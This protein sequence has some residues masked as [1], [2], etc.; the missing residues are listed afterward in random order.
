MSRKMPSILRTTTGRMRDD[1]DFSLVVT[2]W[3]EKTFGN[4]KSPKPLY[5]DLQNPH[6]KQ[7][8]RTWVVCTHKGARSAL[9]VITWL[10]SPHSVLPWKQRNN[11]VCCKG[12]QLQRKALG[13]I[14]ELQQHEK[15]SLGPLAFSS[16]Y[17]RLPKILSASPIPTIPESSF[18]LHYKGFLTMQT[19]AASRKYLSWPTQGH[20]TPLWQRQLW[21]Y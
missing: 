8:A 2:R 19:F 21:G 3:L 6:E 5:K 16:F 10:V 20:R 1:I 12:D 17:V 9:P 11:Y 18:D 4:I 14:K 7:H 13:V 15:T